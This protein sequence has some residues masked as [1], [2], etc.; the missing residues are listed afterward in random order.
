N[1]CNRWR[2][3]ALIRY[4]KHGFHV[5]GQWFCTSTCVAAD[6]VRRFQRRPP[7]RS[8]I[9]PVP[10]LRLGVLLLHPGAITPAQ[11]REALNA[12]R[13]SGL[14]LG[15][16]LQQLGLTGHEAILKALAAQAGIS[17]LTVVDAERVR[18]APGGLCRDEVRALGLV[19]F[20]I[21]QAHH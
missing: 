7:L 19:P 13:E 3:D 18:S 11:L 20:G 8:V 12:Q 16:E 9:P 5:D 21:D 17:Y 4:A 6:A 15:A 14:R 1:D 2:P 10:P